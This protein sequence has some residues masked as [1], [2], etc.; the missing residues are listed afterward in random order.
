M[1]PA[2]L[3]HLLRRLRPS[4]IRTRLT[5][6]AALT[7]LV[8]LSAGGV[9]VAIA[10]RASV[11]QDARERGADQEPWRRVFIEEKQQVS[12]RG[13]PVPDCESTSPMPTGDRQTRFCA[14]RYDLSLVKASLPG[15]PS[16]FDSLTS[17]GTLS[18]NP[19]TDP[20]HGTT[21]IR[22][23]NAYLQF[24]GYV[25][26]VYSMEK[27]QARVNTAIWSL[28][29]GVLGLSALIAA[30][31]WYTI[32]RA[33]RPVEAIR[34]EFAELTAHHL[35]RRITPPREGT[36]VARLAATMNSTLD[37]LQ[38]AI[39]R[40]RQFVADASHELRT[41]LATLRFT[42]E[43]ALSKPH[44]TP[45]GRTVREAHNDTVRL[46]NLTDDLLLLARLDIEEADRPVHK[47]IDLA[48]LVRDETARRRPPPHLAVETRISPD[49][50]TVS[51]R[52]ALLSRVL[53]NL[54][55]NAERHAKS[56]ITITLTR[57]TQRHEAV[58]DVVNDGPPIPAK[59]HQRIFDRFT[60]L[61]HSRTRDTGDRDGSGLGL[62]IARRVV[63]T[64]HGT[65]TVTPSPAGAHFVL[66]LPLHDS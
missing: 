4:A 5:L 54:L 23:A 66:R 58:I 7:S 63:A 15:R 47:T 26:M 12:Y 65:I 24:P 19:F 25:V 57:D 31:I 9:G 17:H 56:T 2:G 33:L 61:D 30:S 59:D 41:P 14:V 43:L 55:D 50:Y 32:G 1:R 34:V 38:T 53:G 52:Q 62:A 28:T 37:T 29:G 64:H 22:H 20:L 16:M 46:E 40:H 45:L 11:L 49:P 13:K 60:R 51:G 36:E 35:D 3:G 8:L 6:L 18:L 10:V 39:D 27:S 42:L 21:P 44:L 48:D